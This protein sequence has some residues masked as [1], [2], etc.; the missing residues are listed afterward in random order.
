LPHITFASLQFALPQE[1]PQPKTKL[2][3]WIWFHL[4]ANKTRPPHIASASTAGS[5]AASSAP[6]TAALYTYLLL[7]LI[8]GCAAQS[9]LPLD[10]NPRVRPPASSTC[11]SSRVASGT[12]PRS[13]PRCGPLPPRSHGTVPSV[14]CGVTMVGHHRFNVL[15]WAPAA[16][17]PELSLGLVTAPK[18]GARASGS[19]P[20]EGDRGSKST[21]DEADLPLSFPA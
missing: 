15:M 12:R 11:T 13:S 14:A 21:G 3:R 9:N 19:L 20:R 18:T 10:P 16:T 4:P 2:P 6:A 17:V 1:D 7:P 8:R 5:M